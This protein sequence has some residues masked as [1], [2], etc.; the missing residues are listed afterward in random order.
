MDSASLTA[1]V[2]AGLF[3]D[4][5]LTEDP[6][7]LP[8]REITL[9]SRPLVKRAIQFSCDGDLAVTADDSVHVFVPEFP[10]FSQ[11][12][13]KIKARADS[14]RY[15]KD[16]V[17]D[18]E[19]DD[20]E[21]AGPGGYNPHSLRAQYSEGSKHM[22]VSFPPIDPRVNRELF[23]IQ[24]LPFPYESAAVD[25]DARSADSASDE[26]AAD[27]EAY[28]SEDED[29]EGAGLGSNRPFGAG[30]GPITGVGSSMN[31]VVCIGWSPSGLG[32]NRRPIL[33]VLT[34]SGTL[35][36]YGDGSKSAN[37]LP[38]ANE[39]MLQRRE[40]NSW[41][42]LWGV[43]ERL[44]VPGQQTEISENIRGFAWA[45]EIAPGQALLATINDVKEVAVISVQ[46]VS[47]VDKGKPME[48]VSSRVEESENMVW[49]VREIL[50]FKAQGPH[51]AVE[52]SHPPGS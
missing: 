43:G 5:D 52:V 2:A 27:S 8:L 34:G 18:D 39:G 29:G 47:G 44:V 46:L 50:R 48:D 3:L 31:H 14:Y 41:I 38:R 11:R 42:F 4:D 17:S 32:V 40:L 20:D 35:G 25:A 12:R 15:R 10:D 23:T 21:N 26:F 49:M 1:P 28:S 22:P 9:N 37:I 19:E 36:M 30:Y 45:S 51:E 33:A 16:E 7:V 24:G 6:K 13:E